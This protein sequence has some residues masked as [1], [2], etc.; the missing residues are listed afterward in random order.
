[1]KMLFKYAGMKYQSFGEASDKI[2]EAYCIYSSSGRPHNKRKISATHINGAFRSESQASFV[3]VYI[4]NQKHFALTVIDL[5][6]HY[7]ER[8]HV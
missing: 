3:L 2:F 8:T 5:G 6:K 7:R 4:G 1:M